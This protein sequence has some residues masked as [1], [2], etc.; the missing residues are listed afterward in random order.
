MVTDG[1]PAIALSFNEPDPRI[2]RRP[3]RKTGE[4]IV[5]TWIFIRYMVVGLYVGLATSG[6]FIYYYTSYDWA[7]H[8]HSIISLSELRNWTKCAESG[9]EYIGFENP[10][11]YF[12]VGK[13]KAGTLSLTVLV[14][15]EMFNSLNAMS[16]NC[17]L[18]KIGF[19]SNLWLWGAIALSTICHCVILYIPFMRNVFSTVS[20]D[21]KDWLLVLA[22]SLPVILIE[23]ILKFLSRNKF[24]RI[25][26][27]GVRALEKKRE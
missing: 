27:V 5:N 24:E 1:F 21:V 19:F 25:D 22:F 26:E 11:D 20:L 14:M 17:S 8:A 13:R 9:A 2:M 7:D 23:E 18:F 12:L 16:E 15:I 10:C 4:K 3:P 6:I